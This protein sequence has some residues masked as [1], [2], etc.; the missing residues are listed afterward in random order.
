MDPDA[1]GLSVWAPLLT[2]PIIGLQTLFYDTIYYTY[3]LSKDSGYAP[4][5]VRMYIPTHIE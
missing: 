5:P 2:P 4:L 1:F 3:P